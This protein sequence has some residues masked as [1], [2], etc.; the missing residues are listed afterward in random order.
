MRSPQL[1]SIP[2]RPAQLTHADPECLASA[3]A[4]EQLEEIGIGLYQAVLLLGVGSAAISEGLEMG[5]MPPLNGALSLAFLLPQGVRELLPILPLLGAAVGLLLSGRLCD[6]WGRK[7]PLM[8]S[9][10]GTCVVMLATASLP[11]SARGALLMLTLRFFAGLAVALGVPAGIVLVVESCSQEARP[12]MVFG[13]MFFGC[14]GLVLSAI[15]LQLFMP[16]LGES[17]DDSWRSL[18]IFI[19]VPSIITLPFICMLCESPTFLAVRGDA[20]GCAQA[21]AYMAW[22][23]GCQPVLE[24]ATP[25]PSTPHRHRSQYGE[26]VSKIWALIIGSRL[27][28]VLCILEATKNIFCIGSAYIWKDLFS[29]SCLDGS[30][31]PA[32]LEIIVILSPI[33]GLILGERVI[34]IGARKVIFLCSI[35]AAISLLALMFETLRLALWALP[36]LVMFTKMTYGPIS[37]CLALMKAE[38]FPTE[39]RVTMFALV[40]LLARLACIGAPSVI[41]VFKADHRA[42]SWYP[43]AMGRYMASLAFAA[44]LTGL[45]ALLVPGYCGDGMSLQDYCDLKEHRPWYR[46]SL[47][48]ASI[49]SFGS[50]FDARP[51]SFSQDGS[52]EGTPMQKER[53]AAAG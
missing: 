44:M 36:V 18:S 20:E 51:R 7:L 39:V 2:R 23:N 13:I 41:E 22:M 15:G 4:S 35:L 14:L 10:L 29:L 26:H 40:S 47:R 21:L 24:D 46:T 45:T 28:S 30:V 37:S 31:T 33:V 34:C 42:V 53:M 19:A 3:G 5:A 27:F 6:R 9:N 43:Y 8:A 49:T 38:A 17:P 11:I 52:G 32:S 50:V 25:P 1:P 12:R 16:Y 48:N